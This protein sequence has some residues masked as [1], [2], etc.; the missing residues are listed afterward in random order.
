MLQNLSA[1]AHFSNIAR[2][3]IDIRDILYALTLQFFALTATVLVLEAKK[4]PAV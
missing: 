3:V 4:Y 2:G 1:N